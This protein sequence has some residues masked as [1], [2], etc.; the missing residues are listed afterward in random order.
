[1][2]LIHILSYNASN[3]HQ[4]WPFIFFLEHK[5]SEIKKEKYI[6]DNGTINPNSHPEVDIP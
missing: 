1:M 5:H 3:N 2:S 6:T 4:R